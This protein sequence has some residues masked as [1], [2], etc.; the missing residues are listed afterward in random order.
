MGGERRG[1]PKRILMALLMV[2]AIPGCGGPAGKP[3]LVTTTPAGET[4]E[5]SGVMLGGLDLGD[6]NGDGRLDI[7]VAEIFSEDGP[8]FEGFV[9]VILQSSAG[10]FAVGVTY[11]AWLS[12]SE[13]HIGDVD[14]DGAADVV[15][16]SWST[17][18]IR[19]DRLTVL[20]GDGAGR[21]VDGGF[22]EVPMRLEDFELA[23]LDGDG[24]PD[25]VATGN[26]STVVLMNSAANPGTFGAMQLIDQRAESVDVGDLD[27]DGAP[28]FA[29]NRGAV[30]TT[31]RVYLQDEGWFELDQD[32]DTG[33]E[34]RAVRIANLDE[35]G[36]PDLIVGNSIGSAE[37]ERRPRLAVFRQ[38]ADAMAAPVFRM[39]TQHPSD[40]WP[41]RRP[42]GIAIADFNADGRLDVA[43]IAGKLDTVEEGFY[44]KFRFKTHVAVFRQSADGTLAAPAQYLIHE[45]VEDLAAADL[46]GDGLPDLAVSGDTVSILFND[47]AA[48][49]T[50]LSPV[51]VGTGAVER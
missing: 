46:N 37:A 11:P 19:S 13:V 26:P 16:G 8:P 18:T 1:V 14:A 35:D 6:L 50:F 4:L 9:T 15:V 33:G 21:L 45:D 20:R 42:T 7:V 32:L 27:G 17:D 40:E 47:P 5:R 25:I 22:V 28:D 30:T 44:P 29:L 34:N 2:A 49:G 41:E 39:P 23:D 48:P 31:A 3:P 36:Y 24:R 51:P 43:A 38:E 12:A 10:A